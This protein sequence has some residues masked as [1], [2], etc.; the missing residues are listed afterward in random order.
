[1][2]SEKSGHLRVVAEN[3]DGLQ[4]LGEKN[5]SAM[6]APF[7]TAGIH[8]ILNAPGSGRRS[9]SKNRLASGYLMYTALCTAFLLPESILN[10]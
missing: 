7:E 1:M 9:P 6:D 3:E 8:E 4:R 5:I 10:R 2:R